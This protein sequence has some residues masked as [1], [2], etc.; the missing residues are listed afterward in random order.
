[1]IDFFN[2]TALSGGVISLNIRSG[3]TFWQDCKFE[4]NFVYNKG[5]VLFLISESSAHLI[6]RNCLFQDNFATT[7]G[8]AISTM[9]GSY[10]DFSSKFLKNKAFQGASLVFSSYSKNSLNGS[11]IRLSFAYDSHNVIVMSLARLEI[12]NMSFEFCKSL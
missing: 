3:E 1:M 4:K 5:G 2:N 7:S 11:S 9:I 10:M 12:I 8:G 6:S